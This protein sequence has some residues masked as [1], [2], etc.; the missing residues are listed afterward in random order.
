MVRSEELHG[1]RGG[2]G[3]LG[4]ES[5]DLYVSEIRRAGNSV[6]V[7][8]KVGIIN[9]TLT[10]EGNWSPKKNLTGEGHCT[11][12]RRVD[13]IVPQISQTKKQKCSC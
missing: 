10:G 13:I 4:G 3:D 11:L 12:S 7:G 5:P 1:V 8:G 6:P 9:K 2:E